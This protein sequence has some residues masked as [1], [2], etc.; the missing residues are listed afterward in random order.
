MWKK[1]PI[2]GLSI[3][4]L[5]GLI[6]LFV[7]QFIVGEQNSQELKLTNETIEELKK[8]KQ[9]LEKQNGTEKDGAEE[10]SAVLCFNVADEQLYSEIYP[11]LKEQDK[12]GIIILR[13]GQLPGD[14]YAIPAEDFYNLMQENWSCAI[15]LERGLESDEE[16]R[17]N[18]ESY[19]QQVQQRVGVIPTIYCVPEGSC[20]QEEAEILEEIGFETVLVHKEN[21]ALES[22]NLQ[23]IK[24]YPYHAQSL[25]KFLSQT[26]GDCGLEVW[27]DWVEE[28]KNNL[29]YSEEDLKEL[30][31]NDEIQIQ[32]LDSLK[33]QSSSNGDEVTG[34]EE[35]VNARLTEI[36]EELERLQK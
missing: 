28:T 33:Q 24:L 30:L 32:N 15:S 13:N 25:M 36:E 23:F 11:L 21:T 7:V 9:R 27:V 16:W 3:L 5:I 14:T 1:G 4:V 19:C 8:E 29:R 6:V 17:Q 18:L 22:Q 34:S 12:T 26:N 20:S 10:N 2:I 35:E 31:Q